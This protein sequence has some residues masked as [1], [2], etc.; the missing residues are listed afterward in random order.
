MGYSHR[1]QLLAILI[2][3]ASLSSSPAFSEEVA[4]T[5]FGISVVTSP[6][7]AT[8]T[9]TGEL[10]EAQRSDYYLLAPNESQ[11]ILLEL[12]DYSV[13]LDINVYRVGR[14]KLFARSSP[15]Q[16]SDS[17]FEDTWFWV[18]SGEKYVI[19]VYG[20]GGV[21]SYRLESKGNQDIASQASYS[22]N[23]DVHKWYSSDR[24]VTVGTMSD[25]DRSFFVNSW[26]FSEGACPGTF[27][28]TCY[29]EVD[30]YVFHYTKDYYMPEVTCANTG[31]LYEEL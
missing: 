31:G 3:L 5:G 29:L 9:V 22:G 11:E 13:N 26:F 18:R 8:E 19:E 17:G 30:N 27:V 4:L 6:I 28:A 24:C 23:F 10:T 21:G 7:S 20:A 25:E 15:N 12:H 14:T 1:K 2:S 16:E